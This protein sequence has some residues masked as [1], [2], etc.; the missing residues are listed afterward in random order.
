MVR[1]NTSQIRQIFSTIFV[2]VLFISLFV[3]PKAQAADLI[4]RSIAL[5]ASWPSAN[6]N[7]RFNFTTATSSN[8][9]SIRFLYCSNSPLEIDPCTAP[10]G[11]NV[12]GAGIASQSGITGFSV[13]GASTANSLI[14][15][16]VPSFTTPVSAEYNF[17]NI[18][19]P[20]TPNEVDYVRITL[21]DNINAT[22]ATVDSGSVV[23]V[24]DDWFNINAYVPPYMTFCVGVTVALD[25]SST[26]GFLADFGEFSNFNPSTVTSQFS[27]ATNDPNGY[28]TF[29]S[30]QTMTSGSNII[31]GLATQT[32]SQPGTTQFGINLRANSNPSVGSNPDAGPVASGIPATSYNS[33]NQ[34]R[35]VS[36][37]LVASANVTTGFNR[38][39]VSYLVNVSADQKPG[40]YAATFTYTAIASF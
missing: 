8:I 38:Y 21:F 29:I 19:N 39:T 30:G 2:F 24:I 1:K 27:V 20:S 17:S 16:R 33:P 25:C 4:N 13:S 28:N 34:F 36:G 31:A 12:A 5:S 35:Y 37:D 26:A 18:I 40:V 11:L 6:V 14:L 10:A 7:H 23:F 32:A 22:G 9:G 15:T 3:I